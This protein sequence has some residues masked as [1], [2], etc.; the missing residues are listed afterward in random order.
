MFSMAVGQFIQRGGG[1][2]VFKNKYP[3]LEINILTRHKLPDLPPPSPAESNGRPPNLR[4]QDLLGVFCVA[5][6]T[7]SKG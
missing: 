5:Y 7:V 2:V 6:C 1:L 4:L 3:G